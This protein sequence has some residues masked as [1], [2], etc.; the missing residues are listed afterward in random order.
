MTTRSI[1]LCAAVLAGAASGQAAGST[2]GHARTRAM[3]ELGQLPTPIDVAVA[4][5]VNF[6]RHRIP[7]PRAGD[8][9]AL[10][11]RFG[12]P[13]FDA[14]GE[15]VLQVGYTGA[16]AADRLDLPPVNL[17]LTIDCSGSMAAAGKLDAVQ[18]ALRV[19]VGRLRPTDRVTL[20]R[21]SE[22][23][24]IVGSG[25]RGDGAWL[26]RAIDTLEPGGATNLH[27]GLLTALR[28]V[29]AAATAGGRSRVILLTDGIANRGVTDPAA[30][31][32]E[33]R[34]YTEEGID[35]TTI[36]VGSELNGD[37][38]D[39]LARSARGMFHFVA[40]ARDVEK[41]FVDEL[42]AQLAAVARRLEL[43]LTLPPG[44]EIV[45]VYG[46]EPRRGDLSGQ[47]RIELPDLYAGGTQVV[48]AMLRLRHA[49]LDGGLLGDRAL[50]GEPMAIGAEL[51]WRDVTTDASHALRQQVSIRTDADGDPLADAEVRKNFTIA[52]VA[53][54]LHDM[55]VAAAARRWVEA[56]RALQDALAFADRTFP[57]HEDEDLRRVTDMARRF[58]DTLRAY[59]DRF[60]DL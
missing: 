18:R 42:Q 9:V 46:Y 44:L 53:Q 57:S 52:R 32:D 37:L 4:D 60:R 45:R 41:V 7:L 11:L 54:A 19:L 24:E 12:S 48:I 17:G 30:I 15:A 27:D 2:Y 3:A 31:L 33:A 28:D 43:R 10:D 34:G 13:A 20:V 51:V 16:E 6:H 5:L 39:R 47:V 50:G 25:L 49:A 1:I 36:G 23:A 22:R 8:A 40:D 56:D 14:R 26:L 29:A 35:L 55:A 21:W 38:L 58:R 59:L